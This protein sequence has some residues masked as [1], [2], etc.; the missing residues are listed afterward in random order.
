M[1]AKKNPNRVDVTVTKDEQL[2]GMIDVKPKD[3]RKADQFAQAINWSAQDPE[4]SGE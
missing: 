1:L 3:I 2:L 4:N